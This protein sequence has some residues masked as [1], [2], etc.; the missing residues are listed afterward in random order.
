MAI[1]V[2]ISVGR[3]GIVSLEEAGM[4]GDSLLVCWDA[5]F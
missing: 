2:M 5:D 3:V 1:S 4:L